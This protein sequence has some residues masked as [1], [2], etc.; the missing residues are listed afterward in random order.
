MLK[1][2]GVQPATR[3]QMIAQGEKKYLYTES[4]CDKMLASASPKWKSYQC[5]GVNSSNWMF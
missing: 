3:F 2:L 5:M 4:K 1:P